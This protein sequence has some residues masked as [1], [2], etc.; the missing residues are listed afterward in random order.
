MEKRYAL[1]REQFKP[2]VDEFYV[3]H[4]WDAER[5]WSTGNSVHP[6]DSLLYLFGS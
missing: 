1:D 5:G 4:G 2:I 6:L 3:L